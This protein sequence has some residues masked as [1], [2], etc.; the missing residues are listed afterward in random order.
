MWKY[1]TANNSYKYIDVLQALV[2]K[3]NNSYHSSIKCT[4]IEA[5]KLENRK[6]VFK[7]LYGK[8]NAKRL[9][10]FRIG[11]RVRITKKKNTFD[12]GFTP[13]WTDEIFTISQIKPTIPITYA[14]KDVRG[15][16]LDGSFY[17]EEL[18]LSHT[19][20]YRVEK[21]LRRRVRNGQKEE[22]VKWRGYDSS[23]NQWIKAN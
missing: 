1:F 4:P 8:N 9:P 13:N 19:D 6:K 14:I 5:Q 2:E 16:E 22:Y 15:E 18:Q 10:K 21:V 23:H 3:Y 7:N 20:T 11:D 12:K 17:E